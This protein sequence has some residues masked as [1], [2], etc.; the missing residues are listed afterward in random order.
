MNWV[1][2][3][4]FIEQVNNIPHIHYIIFVSLIIF[5]VIIIVFII[6]S[7][8]IFK[9]LQISVDNSNIFFYTYNKHT[10]KILEI[11]GNCKIKKI[12]IYKQPIKSIIIYLCDLLS[13][14]NY[15][16]I[17]HKS[18]NYHSALLFEIE[19]NQKR[20]FLLLEKNNS[21]NLTD[22]FLIN[23][24]SEFKEIKLKTNKNTIKTN[25]NLNT[26]LEQTKKRIGLKKF[27]CWNIAEDNCL[28]FTKSIITTLGITNSKYEKYIYKNNILLLYKP[29]EFI[30]HTFNTLC[31]IMNIIERYLYEHILY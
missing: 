14:F 29:T 27:Y 21:I 15:S 23:N 19:F 13:L 30:T 7:Y 25:L 9:L 1:N 6:G 20:K 17:L 24:H 11:Y 8:F 3:T 2:I 5:I 18:E 10:Q 26:L 4:E 12:Y 16:S 22:K 31:S 28:E